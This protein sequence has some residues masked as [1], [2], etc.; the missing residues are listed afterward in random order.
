MIAAEV[1]ALAERE[2]S[3]GGY[4]TAARLLERAAVLTPDP[5]LR[6]ERLLR[7]GG[8]E[9]AA[10][11]VDQAGALLAQATP[12]LRGPTP[13]AESIRLDGTIRLAAGRGAEAA[14]TLV[15][16]GQKLLALN[17]AAARDS[18]L[19]AF[20]A[21][22]YAGWST[23]GPLLQE[24][25][26]SAAELAETGATDV[27]ALDLLVQAYAQRASVGYTAAVPAFRRAVDAFLAEDLDA[28]VVLQR[29]LLAINAA[30]ELADLVAVESLTERWIR[31][32]RDSGALTILSLAL[33]VRGVFADVP[34]GRL[35]DAT[36]AAAESRE[37]AH[38]TGNPRVA[39]AAGNGDLMTLVVSGREADARATAARIRREARAATPI[40]ATYALGVLELS[41]GN[42]EAAA[43][44]LDK[45]C[46]GDVPVIG[47]SALPLL[48]EALA[49]LRQPER[50]DAALRR[51]EERARATGTPLALGLLARSQALLADPG[52]ARDRY[53]EAIEL[54]SQSP[55]RLELART[56][57]LYGEWLRRQRRRREA[58]DQLRTAFDLFDSMGADG[59]A[60]RARMELRATGEQV[61]RRELG[62]PE[63][64]TPQEAQ[65]AGLVSQGE[66]NRDIAARLFLSPSTVE[67][68]LR[69]VFRK[70]GVTSRTQL[71][72]RIMDD[73]L[74]PSTA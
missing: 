8:A 24:I 29:S 74:A 33:T 67:Y 34:H 65:I 66:A 48:V 41:L 23:Q 51:Y 53:E 49:R 22:L 38:A 19:A 62:A 17:P 31:I 59:F 4:S 57:L 40:F 7:S 20:E 35:A 6:A 52:H 10:G 5:S 3:R 9:L 27:P 44:C 18:L 28:D 72:R 58:R 12:R 30:A 68:H 11:A 63:R 56:H 50:A 47:T 69:K 55:A 16:A 70:L 25:A 13:R 15:R 71:L 2:R 46:H 1:E 42:Y 61:G 39:G 37:L 73:D 21:V 26:R 43:A 45:V 32:A 36:A 64:L 54:L 60:E 14:S